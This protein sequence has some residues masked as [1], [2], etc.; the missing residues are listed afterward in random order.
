MYELLLALVRQK[1]LSRYRDLKPENVLLDDE[2][3]VKLVDFGTAKEGL[4][5]F[6]LVGTPEYLSPEVI[7]GKGSA[8]RGGRGGRCSPRCA[9]S[10]RPPL[11]PRA[12][13]DDCWKRPKT[14]R[15]ST[16]TP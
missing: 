14:T 13:S 6:T 4:S 1:S 5:S 3:Y 16:E 10:G 11:C 2:G 8:G 15:S 9:E 7:L 12:H